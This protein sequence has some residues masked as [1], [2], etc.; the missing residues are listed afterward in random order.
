MSRLFYKFLVLSNPWKYTE[1][2][3]VDYEDVE[4]MI[5]LYCSTRNVNAE[6]V[7]LVAELAYVQPVQDV[8][9]LSQQYGVQDPCTKNSAVVEQQGGR[10]RSQLYHSTVE[11]FNTG[12]LM[13]H[14]SEWL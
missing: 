9:P 14:T 5:A 11:K 3:L 12:V 8:T 7:E 1:M 2:K 10:T 6:Q 4:I 13:H